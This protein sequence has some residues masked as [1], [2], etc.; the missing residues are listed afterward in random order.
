MARYAGETSTTTEAPEGTPSTGETL[1]SRASPAFRLG[2]LE[3]GRYGGVLLDTRETGRVLAFVDGVAT[4]REDVV[5]HLPLLDGTL[6]G[7]VEGLH[8]DV[9]AMVTSHGAGL[10][11]GWGN[12]AVE[13][14]GRFRVDRLER[15]RRYVV[16]ALE[17]SGRAAL[18]EPTEPAQ[19]VRLVLRPG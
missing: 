17:S 18:S 3:S 4:G 11:P 5:L 6:E 7:V 10:P 14:D 8:P 9:G 2:S 19:V 16:E 13:P 12:V 1:P 15:G